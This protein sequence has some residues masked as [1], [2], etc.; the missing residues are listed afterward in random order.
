M[1]SKAYA[2][3]KNMSYSK[4]AYITSVIGTVPRDHHSKLSHAV[5]YSK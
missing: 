1:S 5:L 3:E 2:R 4:H